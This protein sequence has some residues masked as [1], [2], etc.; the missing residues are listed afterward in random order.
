MRPLTSPTVALAAICLAA[1][2]VIVA[3]GVRLNF[4]NDDWYFLLQRPGMESHGGLD[5][6]LAPHNGSMG[7]A[8]AAAFKVLVA[9]FGMGSQWPYRLLVGLSWA[10]LGAV[11]FAVVRERVPTPV[12][13]VIVAVVVFLGP[14]W[15]AM[16]FISSVNHVWALTFGLAALLAL[17]ADTPRRNALACALLVAAVACSNTGLALAVGAAVAVLTRRRPR[18]LWIVVVPVAVYGAW[19]LGYG[20]TQP[21]GVTAAH[22]TALPRYAFDSLSFGLASLLGL[23]HSQLPSAIADGHLPAVL[24]IAALAVLLVRGGR[25]RVQALWFA[26]ALIAFWLF[27]GASAIPG[28]GANASRYQVTDAVL[29]LVLTA[30]LVRGWRFPRP[31]VIAIGVAGLVILASNLIVL[32]DG[33]RFLRTDAAFA[34]ADTGALQIARAHAAPTTWLLA[35]VAGDPYLSGITARRYFAQTAAHGTPHFD[36]P[37]SLAAEP[38]AQRTAAD[39]VL[40]AAAQIHA[41]IIG[42]TAEGPGCQTLSVNPAARSTLDIAAGTTRIHSRGSTPLA[43]FL[44]RFGPPASPHGVAFLPGGA[45]ES[46]TIPLDRAA[47]PWRLTIVNPRGAPAA[48]T[49]C[50]A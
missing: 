46:L 37:A 2:A 32:R 11:V 28:R 13:L 12:A 50:P 5:V 3:L 7:F 26:S 34:A 23:A 47:Q 43:L 16:L 30:E 4:F 15:E 21:T 10:A 42:G 25:P 39:G 33:Y 44:S 29:L 49:V 38:A 17:E 9:V 20:H 19:W 6:L 45:T 35:P 24:A 41:A 48:V 36:T 40:I 1:A 18:Q 8:V 31:A 22:I 14:A 27:T